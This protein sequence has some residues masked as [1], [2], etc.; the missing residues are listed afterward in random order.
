MEKMWAAAAAL[1]LLPLL[2]L[3]ARG[4]TG[5]EALERQ[6]ELVDVEGLRRAAEDSG[7]TAQYGASLDEGLEALLDTGTREL[8]GAVRPPAPAG[9][10]LQAIQI[11]LAQAE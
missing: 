1:A 11:L 6:E 4:L 7:G 5:Q 10:Q 8:G 9:A 3:P 2:C